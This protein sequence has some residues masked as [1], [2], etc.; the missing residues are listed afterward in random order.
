[1]T[2]K[3]ELVI[4]MNEKIWEP[5]GIFGNYIS[6]CFTGLT[7]GAILGGYIGATVGFTCAL[8]SPAITGY[9]LVR[10]GRKILRR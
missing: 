5:K 7:S 9:G 10:I 3:E 8:L 6:I 4:R 2:K 1:M